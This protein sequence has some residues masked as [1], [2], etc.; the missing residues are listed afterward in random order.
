MQ[1]LKVSRE[2]VKQLQLLVKQTGLVEQIRA[3]LFEQ[4][5]QTEDCD[6]YE[7]NQQMNLLETAEKVLRR[8]GSE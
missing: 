7:I 2:Q 4:W 3:D 6:W 1:R 5:K 8:M